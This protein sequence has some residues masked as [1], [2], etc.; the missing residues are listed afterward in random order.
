[1]DIKKL[2]IYDVGAYEKNSTAGWVS[3]RVA[4]DSINDSRRIGVDTLELN[5]LI[6]RRKILR[7][8][9]IDTGVSVWIN[10]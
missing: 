4:A 7:T 8:D 6:E 2:N 9:I 5:G 3:V 10:V 1:L